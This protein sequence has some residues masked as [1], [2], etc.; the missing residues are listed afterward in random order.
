MLKISLIT[1]T[2]NSIGTIQHCL[3]SVHSQTYENTEHIVIDGAS[4]DGTLEILQQNSSKIKYLHSENDNG[5]YYA[6]NKGILKAS[7]DVIGFLH[8][9][10][11]F[12]SNNILEIIANEF[13]DSNVYAVYGDLNYVDKNQITNITRRWKSCSFKPLYL[14]FGW[15]PPHPTLFIRRDW[16]IK[17]SGFNLQYRISSDYETIVK[18][19]ACNSIY[20]I[21]Y[22]PITFI[23]MRVGGLSNG[24]LRNI[25]L[26]NIEDFN[27]IYNHYNNLIM[28]LFALICKSL[29]KLKQL[30]F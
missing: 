16:Y 4:T 11:F 17:N 30:R 9:D 26:K 3:N 7:G 28:A 2:Y 5:I 10:D 24:H 27:I 21:N 29:I 20:K 12:A 15:M 23:N 1:A 13:N 25:F 19:F 6:L 8:S 14:K 18:L 22:I